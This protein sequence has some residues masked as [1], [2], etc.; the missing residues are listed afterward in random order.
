MPPLRTE[1][2]TVS[3]P[4][5]EWILAKRRANAIA[6][7]RPVS[8]SSSGSARQTAKAL[9]LT[10]AVTRK[11]RTAALDVAYLRQPDGIHIKRVVRRPAIS[12]C[13]PPIPYL[14]GQ[15]GEFV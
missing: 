14:E 7:G 4:P 9:T 2:S 3:I 10:L 12:D 11:R 1:L 13:A 6:H 15:H 5:R 8:H